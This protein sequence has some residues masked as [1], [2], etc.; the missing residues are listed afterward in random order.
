MQRK[1]SL[2][3]LSRLYLSIE[4]AT[5]QSS[6]LKFCERN[7]STCCSI[8][9]YHIC[10]KVSMT[11][12]VLRIERNSTLQKLLKFDRCALSCDVFN[13]WMSSIQWTSRSIEMRNDVEHLNSSQQV[14]E[15]EFVKTSTKHSSMRNDRISII[16]TTL[17]FAQFIVQFTSLK[18]YSICDS[19]QLSNKCNNCM[20]FEVRRSLLTLL[21]I[22]EFWIIWNFLIDS[23]LEETRHELSMI[24]TH[25]NFKCYS[26]ICV[27]FL[28]RVSIARKFFK[29][30]FY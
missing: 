10:Y 30:I 9:N 5:R 12:I 28:Y 7:C 17:N 1:L 4:R 20:S 21:Q 18:L 25:N 26:S 22:R 11:W 27:V 23:R 19:Y 2:W 24:K 16:L 8:D 14:H 29:Q 6:N 13:V 15:I 3:T